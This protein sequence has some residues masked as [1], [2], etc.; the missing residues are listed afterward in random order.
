MSPEP[1]RRP[2]PRLRRGACARAPRPRIYR[3]VWLGRSLVFVLAGAVACTFYINFCSLVFACGC[4]SLWNG[5]VDFCNIHVAG[6]RH[7]PWC[8]S[9]YWGYVPLA[10]ILGAQAAASFSRSAL[11]LGSRLVLALALFPVVGGAFAAAFGWVTG[12]WADWTGRTGW[13]GS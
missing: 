11:G 1:E 6:V 3:G 5:G 10:G 13:T 2:S 8:T 9:G 7:C 12:Y 4:H